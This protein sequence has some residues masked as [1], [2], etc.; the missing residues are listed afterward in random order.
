[1]SRYYTDPLNLYSYKG[2]DILNTRFGYMTGVME[3]WLNV[4]NLLDAY[5]AVN[6]SR[7]NFGTSYSMGEPR[8]F[9]LGISYDLGKI[10]RSKSN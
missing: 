7:S 1:M 3:I 5:Y 8:N 2:F 4:I 9:T 10:I 6:S